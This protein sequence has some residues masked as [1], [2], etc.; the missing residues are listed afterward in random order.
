MNITLPSQEFDEYWI[1]DLYEGKIKMLKN[2]KN[3]GK[4]LIFVPT[5]NLDATWGIIF[6]LLKEGKLWLYAKTATMKPNPN[7]PDLNIKVIC[8]YTANYKN[9]KNVVDI[10]WTLWEAGVKIP[11][12]F[13]Y[14]ADRDTGGTKYA[15]QGAKN[16]SIYSISQKM[17]LEHPTKREFLKFF[18]E[19]YKQS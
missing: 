10:L 11:K 6:K 3:S 16:I 19:K 8:V 12:V 5:E 4:W 2:T 15:N 14:K 9:K 18:L 1:D 7:A 13:N 17:L